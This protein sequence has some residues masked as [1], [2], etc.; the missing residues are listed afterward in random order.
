MT[1]KEA[2]LALLKSQV[3]PHFLFNNLNN[4]Y[5]L[6][7]RKNENALTVIEM[8]SSLLRYA[9]YEQRD[10]VTLETEIA[11]L[12]NYIELQRLR[13]DSSANIHIDVENIDGTLL[14]S[15]HLLVS[16]SENAFKHGD[17]TDPEQ[18]LTV[19]GYTE[20][21]TFFYHVF[22][23]KNTFNKPSEV[24]IGLS[25]VKRRLDLLYP[26]KYNLS[27]A[28]GKDEFSIDLRIEL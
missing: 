28:D 2:E 4:I 16:F 18:P 15:P 10:Q 14:I 19:T 13:I 7:Y 9:L 3:N 25:N 23:K 22:N 12:K 8:L 20:D 1:I 27:I 24:G 11:Y 21:N 17:M 5:A 26:G 6:V